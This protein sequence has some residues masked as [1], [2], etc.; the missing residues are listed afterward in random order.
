MGFLYYVPGISTLV[1]VDRE[2][3]GMAR[4]EERDVPSEEDTDP[5]E[6]DKDVSHRTDIRSAAQ[7]VRAAVG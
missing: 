2:A 5:G 3:L 7:R 6:P 1:E 4:N